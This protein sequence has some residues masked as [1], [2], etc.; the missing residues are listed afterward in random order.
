MTNGSTS[1]CARMVYISIPSP[2][3]LLI[4]GTEG[5]ALINVLSSECALFEKFIA[6]IY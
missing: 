6:I 2:L 1:I 3:S 5:F 4:A